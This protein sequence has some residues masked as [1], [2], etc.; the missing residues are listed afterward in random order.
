[1]KLSQLTATA[2]LSLVIVGCSSTSPRLPWCPPCQ[3]EEAK[4]AAGKAGEADVT[5]AQPK[6]DAA[7]S[8]EQSSAATQTAASVDYGCANGVDCP[9]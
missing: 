5:L 3:K 2:V 6:P 7:T 8:A 9:K 1:M 4:Q